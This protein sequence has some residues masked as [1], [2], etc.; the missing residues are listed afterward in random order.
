MNDSRIH[1]NMK[2]ARNDSAVK[3]AYWDWGGLPL[4]ASERM[5]E[6]A[7]SCSLEAVAGVIS[8]ASALT[9]DRHDEPAAMDLSMIHD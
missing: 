6:L 7:P 1:R 9:G 2:I 5:L 4:Y 8:E 3:L